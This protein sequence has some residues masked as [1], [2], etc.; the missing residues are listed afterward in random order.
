M[1]L[2]QYVENGQPSAEV[3][4]EEIPAL[5]SAGRIRADTLM[6]TP[7]QAEWHAAGALGFFPDPAV[8]CVTCSECGGLTPA[9]QAVILGASP[10]CAACRPVAL[11]RL[12]EHGAVHLSQRG[13]WRDG[14]IV[15][16]H[17]EADLGDACFKCGEAARGFKLKR[18]LYWHPAWLYILILFPGL[19]IYVIVAVCVRKTA[20]V[21]VPVCP[22]HRARRRAL[23]ATATTLLIVTIA[24]IFL[25]LEP[26]LKN[27]A[28]QLGVCAVLSFLLM[29]ICFVRMAQFIVPTK[30]DE[31]HVQLRGAK[32]GY[33]SL[34]A[35]W[36]GWTR[37]PSGKR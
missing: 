29:L 16:M 37:S 1:Q 17:R 24:S 2:W 9:D 18:K 13:V 23:I 32:R 12:T 14:K 15:V 5:I 25:A 19:L 21:H 7:G 34:L 11:Q 8:E 3:A 31:T 27:A 6:W 20:V 28:G 33:L 26:S 22:R 35:V 30:I 36:P 10:V 4:E